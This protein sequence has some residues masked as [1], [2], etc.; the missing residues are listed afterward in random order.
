MD[1]KQ[2][3]TIFSPQ[4]MRLAERRAHS[5]QLA[6]G[7]TWLSELIGHDVLE[8]LGFLRCQPGSALVLGDRAGTLSP[9]LEANGAD[10]TAPTEID[11]EQPLA[12]GTFDLIVSLLDLGTV[13]DL[14]GA[15]I[16]LRLALN[17]GGLLIAA[18][19]GAGSLPLVRSAMMTSDGE[20]PA[21]R[22]HPQVDDR[23]A[24]ALMQ[25]AGFAR[26]VV[27]RYTI[28]ARYDG[29]ANLVSDL[30]DQGLGSVLADRAP[31][32]SRRQYQLARQA[33]ASHADESGR[34]PES[35]EVVTMTGWKS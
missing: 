3:P 16:Q 9:A 32:L 7:T 35:F 2:V 22:I 10:V 31:T 19:V 27:D 18:L 4:R 28:T 30:R 11:L 26:Q 15:L 8:R 23:A 24:S 25:R 20:R 14:P 1:G 5:R 33:F 17:P 29:L 21:A 6:G 34:I 12:L 13:N